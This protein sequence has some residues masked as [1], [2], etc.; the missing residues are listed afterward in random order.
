MSPSPPSMVLCGQPSR[1]PPLGSVSRDFGPISRIPC[2]QQSREPPFYSQMLYLSQGMQPLC[3]VVSLLPPWAWRSLSSLQPRPWCPLTFPDVSCFTNCVY[4]TNSR[5][6]LF[7]LVVC[8]ICSGTRLRKSPSILLPFCLLHP[9]LHF[10]EF[11]LACRI[12][13]WRDWCRETN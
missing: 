5:W 8:S 12:E 9:G 13:A 3:H 7:N 2:H 1:F 10:K 11:T 4:F 6:M